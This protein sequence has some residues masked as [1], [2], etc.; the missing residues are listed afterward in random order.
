ML[1]I[2]PDS[3]VEDALPLLTPCAAH[4]PNKSGIDYVDRAAAIYSVPASDLPGGSRRAKTL[5]S[6]YESHA[7]ILV[8]RKFVAGW[9]G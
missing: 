8:G 7:S 3:A 1:P 2:C 4:Y 5:T 6:S 9:A